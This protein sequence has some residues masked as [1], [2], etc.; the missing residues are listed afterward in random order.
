MNSSV[1]RCSS[2]IMIGISRRLRCLKSNELMLI[3]IEVGSGT[4]SGVGRPEARRVGLVRSKKEG[5]H[6]CLMKSL[7]SSSRRKCRNQGNDDVF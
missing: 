6:H 3:Y 5:S 1:E 2:P 7:E 4:D